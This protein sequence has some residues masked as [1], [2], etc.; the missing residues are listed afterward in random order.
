M[1][2]LCIGPIRGT[3]RSSV[4][5]RYTVSRTPIGPVPNFF[6]LFNRSTTDFSNFR[7]IRK[8][9]AFV[10]TTFRPL[11]VAPYAHGVWYSSESSR[12]GGEQQVQKN[13]NNYNRTVA[14][15]S[16]L[17]VY[18]TRVVSTAGGNGTETKKFSRSAE[19]PGGR[20]TGI[21]AATH[22]ARPLRLIRRP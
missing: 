5:C 2:H 9:V 1:S 21:T 11:A 13:N 12:L 22:R 10:T 17:F 19:R 6:F 20:E 8:T 7:T 3:H 14:P 15:L 4:S 18:N 16:L